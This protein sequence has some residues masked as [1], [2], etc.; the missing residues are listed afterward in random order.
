MFLALQTISS[1]PKFPFPNANHTPK[2]TPNLSNTSLSV[3]H[4]PTTPNFSMSHSHLTNRRFLGNQN[5]SGNSISLAIQSLM[6]CPKSSTCVNSL[7][8]EG[9][10]TLSTGGGV[11][12]NI[13]GQG[14]IGGNGRAGSGSTGWSSGGGNK[15]SGGG[16][17]GMEEW[18]WSCNFIIIGIAS[19]FCRLILGAPAIKDKL[20]SAVASGIVQPLLSPILEK[21]VK[22]I[23]PAVA[24]VLVMTTILS[25]LIV[26][27]KASVLVIL[28]AAAMLIMELL[29]KVGIQIYAKIYV[30]YLLFLISV[31]FLEH[32]LSGN[33]FIQVGLV[34]AKI[35]LLYL[36][37]LFCLQYDLS[38]LLLLG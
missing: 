14:G 37:C 1:T 24:P 6:D 8:G 30:F 33:S 15:D 26:A 19:S 3:N 17:G 12:G 11:D 5:W 29:L 7:R 4:V 27:S 10:A 21:S 2:N 36:I 13:N 32:N 18:E 28:S 23:M 35:Y 31:I 34:L 25:T 38:W 20:L 9:Y 16:G 22:Q